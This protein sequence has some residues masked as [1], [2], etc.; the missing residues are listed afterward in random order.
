MWI[1]RSYFGEDPGIL[2]DGKPDDMFP[3]GDS[4]SGKV[5]G[6]LSG[7]SI[8]KNLD[9]LNPS[10]AA[11]R[12]F[13]STLAMM[14]MI[15]GILGLPIAFAAAP[16]LPLSHNLPALICVTQSI[17]SAF[18]MIVPR[19]F[20][21]DWRTK[22]FGVPL[23]YVGSV[24]IVGVIPWL[25]IVCFSVLPIWIR[26]L[27]LCSYAIPITW[28]CRRFVVYY[29]EA[30]SNVRSRHL[31]YQEE[32]DAIYYLQH[33]DDELFKKRKTLTHFPSNLF[34]ALAFAAA[35]AT[36]PFSA[37]LINFTG[38]PLIHLF[39]T[40]TGLPIVL[41]CFGFATRGFLIFYYYPYLLK[42]TTGKDVYVIMG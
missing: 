16:S 3:K 34:F 7:D 41:M 20:R 8:L 29:H 28:W 10:I 26:L 15:M 36:V 6:G 21:W 37:T 12:T 31:L 17:V 2:F 13:S 4:V 42:R 40:I 35:V 18:L 30:F 9:A 14:P 38:T 33:N 1:D 39:L 19:L 27:V 5:P 23:F 11:P 32:L 24:S 25:S 22:Y